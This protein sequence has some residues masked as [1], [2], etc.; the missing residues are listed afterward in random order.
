MR[1]S[2]YDPSQLAL[3]PDSARGPDGALDARSGPGSGWSPG[4]CAG[5]ASLAL[6]AAGSVVGVVGVVGVELGEQRLDLL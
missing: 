1:R 2:D 3:T 6:G 5:S 4:Q